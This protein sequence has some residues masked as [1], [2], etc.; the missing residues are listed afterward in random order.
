MRSTL[1]PVGGGRTLSVN[2]CPQSSHAN[3]VR[4]SCTDSLCRRRPCE[5]V[6]EWL[7]GRR[8]PEQEEAKSDSEGG[9]SATA[10]SRLSLASWPD[11]HTSHANGLFVCCVSPG[12]VSSVPA[13]PLASAGLAGAEPVESSKAACA[14]C[15]WPSDDI[16]RGNHQD[17]RHQATSK[18]QQEAERRWE[19]ERTGGGEE[20]SL[21]KKK[22][23]LTRRD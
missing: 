13:T 2:S 18:E 23:R 17:T 14:G 22:K 6:N 5:R 3:G 10:S 7:P 4:C 16:G 1:R 15:R 19:W 21:T 11:P 9:P 8:E 20:G 12:L